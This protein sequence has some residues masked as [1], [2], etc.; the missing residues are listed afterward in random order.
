MAVFPDKQKKLHQELDQI[1]GRSR[2]PM[3][4][5]RVQLAYTDA[6]IHETLR[7]STILPFSLLHKTT[8][9]IHFWG[10]DI[11]KDTMIVPNLYDSNFN[12]KVWG[13]PENFRPERFLTDDGKFMK[14]NAFFP[15]SVGKRACLGETLAR[16][17]L[18]IF[19]SGLFQKFSVSLDPNQLVPSLEA[20]FNQIC[21]PDPHQLVIKERNRTY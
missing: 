14:N 13:D 4:S 16:D 3:L 1:L 19:V 17:E 8:T 11:P 20:K 7:F 12:A 9:D 5:N 18:I 6:V 21:S 15:F 2:L 10:Y